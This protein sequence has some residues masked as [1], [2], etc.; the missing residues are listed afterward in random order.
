VELSR[1]PWRAFIETAPLPVLVAAPLLWPVGESWDGNGWAF[2]CG[3]TGVHLVADGAELVL[4]RRAVRGVCR[5][6][7]A[8][9][10]SA[11]ISAHAEGAEPTELAALRAALVDDRWFVPWSMKQDIILLETE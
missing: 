11:L 3:E 10:L 7:N 1:N 2:A 5:K 9:A 6:F 4:P 8:L